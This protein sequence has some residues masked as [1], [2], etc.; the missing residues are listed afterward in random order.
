VN[1]VDGCA[2]WDGEGGYEVDLVLEGLEF[3]CVTEG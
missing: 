1:K 2:G 3:L